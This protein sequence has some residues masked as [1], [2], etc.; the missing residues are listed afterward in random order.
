M[1]ETRVWETAVLAVVVFMSVGAWVVSAS[2]PKGDSPLVGPAL[3]P[4]VLGVILL[5]ASIGVFWE[6]RKAAL[7]AAREALPSPEPQTKFDWLKLLRPI[8]V[9]FLFGLAPLMLANVG[10]LATV[11]IVTLCVCLL[12]GAKPLETGIAS[13]FMVGFVYLVFILLLKMQA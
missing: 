8:G 11:G 10:L 13:L 12:L 3:F 5:I 2:F 9:L 7:Q 1:K 4:R 6:S